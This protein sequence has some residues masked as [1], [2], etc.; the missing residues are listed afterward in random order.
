MDRCGKDTLI[1]NL[2]STRTNYCIRHWST[3][4]GNTDLEKR[5]YQ[6]KFFEKEFTIASNLLHLDKN[7]DN[8]IIW[9]RAHLGEFVYG[10]MY[11]ET[12]PEEWVFP[13]EKQFEFDKNP[14]IY[15]L[16]LVAPAE[17]LCKRD[18]GES[19][20]TDVDKKNIEMQNFIKAFTESG[21]QHKLLLNVSDGENYLS[22]EDI[23]NTINNFLN[24]EYRI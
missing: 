13:L 18:D 19:F 1:S 9:N 17:F 6:E 24:N 16:L 3:P 7:P 15:L 5:K 2:I 21:I 14:N 23:T 20:T 22:K 10:K 4:K 8:L 11:R 12:N